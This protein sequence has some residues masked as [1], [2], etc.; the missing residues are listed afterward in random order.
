M[1]DRT[2]TRSVACARRAHMYIL[3]Y[4]CIAVTQTAGERWPG[5]TVMR[6]VLKPRHV[7]S[8]LI[9]RAEQV[10]RLLGESTGGSNGT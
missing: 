5:Y 8:L 1:L 2:C 7:S 3:T 6:L 9:E 4:N 10:N